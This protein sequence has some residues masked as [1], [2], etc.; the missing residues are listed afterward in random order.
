ML[1]TA[2]HSIVARA[3]Q[4]FIVILTVHL[5]SFSKALKRPVHESRPGSLNELS[6]DIC[7][8]LLECDRQQDMEVGDAHAPASSGSD[9]SSAGRKRDCCGELQ[10]YVK[11]PLY[12]RLADS[13][14]DWLETRSILELLNKYINK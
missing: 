12:F 7:A 9:G 2:S 6:E 3:S 13:I 11:K 5:Y 4:C 10:G 8:G 14:E 1:F